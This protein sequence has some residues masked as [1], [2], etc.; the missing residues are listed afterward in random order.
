MDIPSENVTNL[1]SMVN[2]FAFS[3]MEEALFCDVCGDSTHTATFCDKDSSEE[4][5]QV[6]DIDTGK[7]FVITPDGKVEPVVV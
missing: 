5:W 6:K 4:M 3:Y 1:N 7:L 2:S